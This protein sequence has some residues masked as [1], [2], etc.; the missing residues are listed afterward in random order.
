MPRVEQHRP[1]AA[2]L[3]YA[4]PLPWHRRRRG[5]ILTALLVVSL[6]VMGLDRYGDAAWDRVQVLYWQ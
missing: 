1:D 5:R 6:L 2:R 4:A 3:E